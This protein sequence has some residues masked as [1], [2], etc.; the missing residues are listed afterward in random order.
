MTFTYSFEGRRALVVGGSSGIGNGI[1][2][3]FK[4]AGADVHV[5]GTRPSAA[6]YAGEE[7]SN[8]EGLHY[9]HVDVSSDAAVDA[10]AAPFD[11]LDVLVL[12]P[13]STKDRLRSLHGAQPAVVSA[14]D[15]REPDRYGARALDSATFGQDVGIGTRGSEA[16]TRCS[17][18]S[19]S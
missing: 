4:A 9:S 8:L 3:A 5:W 19:L 11:T 18:N 15:L 13:V 10:Y 2:R 6:A 17:R 1:A 12:V 7:G 14:G 16:L